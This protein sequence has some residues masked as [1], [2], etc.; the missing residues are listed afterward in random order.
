MSTPKCK[1]FR[2]LYDNYIGENNQTTQA[3][4]QDYHENQNTLIRE[5]CTNFWQPLTDYPAGHIIRSSNMPAGVWAIVVKAG[6]S[7]EEEPTWD[8]ANR[9]VSDGSVIWLMFYLKITVNGIA[10]DEE[11]NIELDKS[12]I[13]LDKVENTPDIEKI[14]AQAGKVGDETIGGTAQPVYIKDGIPEALTGNIGG[15]AQPIYMLEGVLKALGITIGSASK[16]VYIDAGVIKA[17]ST[18]LGASANG[19]IIAQSLGT[20]GYV[21]FANGLILQWGKSSSS[22]RAT[23]TV[24]LPISMASAIYAVAISQAAASDTWSTWSSIVSNTQI[25][26]TNNYGPGSW[27][28]VIGKQ[29][30]GSVTD[31]SNGNQQRKFTFP[32]SFTNTNYSVSVT[33][34]HSELTSYGWG[35]INTKTETYVTARVA[36]YTT[37]Y[38][39]IGFQQWGKIATQS[40]GIITL[41]V[42]FQN[43]VCA[44]VTT[45]YGLTTDASNVHVYAGVTSYSLTNFSFYAAKNAQGRMWIAI[46]K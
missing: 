38:I 33:S 4:L 34:T 35:Y 23:T 15:S 37:H 20:N 29:Q 27:W 9:R 28:L 16:P 1:D 41:P 43:I 31:S 42:A 44:I 5:A 12:D 8:Y 36:G 26:L 6:T 32:V 30:W 22:G 11:G 3:E 17:C 13:G 25:K 2:G 46:G 10:A 18:A 24:T 14:V 19:G 7:G 45:A 40:N 21:K 39:V